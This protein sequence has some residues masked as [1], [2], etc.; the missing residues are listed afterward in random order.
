MQV[1]PRGLK[2]EKRWGEQFRKDL[3]GQVEEGIQGS[4]L[5]TSWE[6]HFTYGPRS[7]SW[8]N[9]VVIL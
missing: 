1:S 9:S 2:P 5:E 3:E 6:E 4:L 8:K 7:E